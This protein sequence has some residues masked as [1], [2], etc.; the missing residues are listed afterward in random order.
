MQRSIAEQTQRKLETNILNGTWPAGS[1]LPAERALAESLEVS[2]NALR[3]AIFALKA[4]GLLI[5]RRGS[6]VFVTEVLQASITSPWRQLVADHPDLRWDTLEFRSE[7]EAATAYYAALRANTEDLDKIERVIARLNAA[8]D[9]GDK[10]EEQQGDADFHQAI[11][12]ASHNSVF[13]YLNTGM[14]RM[15]REH[16][17]LNL[18]GLEDGTGRVTR[19]LRDQHGAIRDAIRNHQPEV[20]RQRMLEHI[21]FTRTELARR[22]D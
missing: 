12:E 15:L 9:S 8:Y 1:R 13:L 6:G 14:L 4:R 16:I 22:E 20:A 17:G 10:N 7:L 3:E 18:Q 2:R 19:M 21:A 11:A 5:S